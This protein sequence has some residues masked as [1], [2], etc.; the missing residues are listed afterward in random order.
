MGIVACIDRGTVGGL[1]E[2]EGMG[3]QNIDEQDT[4]WQNTGRQATARVAHT[5]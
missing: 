2:L 3:G 4:G 5:W 1:A